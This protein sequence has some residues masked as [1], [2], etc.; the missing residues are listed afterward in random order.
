[1][2]AFFVGTK[3]IH[4]SLAVAPMFILDLSFWPW[5]GG[6]MLSYMSASTLLTLI[7][8]GTHI[9]EDTAF[10]EAD[11]DDHLEHDWGQ[12]V[13]MTSCD[14]APESEIAAFFFGAATP[15]ISPASVRCTSR[16]AGG[17]DGGAPERRA[18]SCR[19]E[20]D[21]KCRG[22]VALQEMPAGQG[23]AGGPAA[24]HSSACASS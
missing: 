15:G 23:S 20:K 8:V 11:E 22:S 1:M 13:V 9:H 18:A 7:L 21:R 5:F 17:G 19:C 3:A 24:M 16:R 2:L 10:P 12:H 6:Y 14:W 4:I